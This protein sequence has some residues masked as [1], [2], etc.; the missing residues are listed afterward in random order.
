VPAY[1]V[2]QLLQISQ[3]RGNGRTGFVQSSAAMADG[4]AAAYYLVAPH[5]GDP[6]SLSFTQGWVDETEIVAAQTA[7]TFDVG[8]QVI[9]NGRGG[10]IEAIDGDT[11][12]VLVDFG[13]EYS[14]RR[15]HRYA[16]PF[17][18]LAVEN[19]L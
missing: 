10:E 4:G 3:S 18:R 15:V 11:H 12:T 2:G 19:S 13:D 6:D 5:W 16:V 9:I 7:P 8:D 17:W 1:Q 14:T